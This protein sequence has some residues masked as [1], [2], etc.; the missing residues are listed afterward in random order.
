MTPKIIPVRQA[1]S[2]ETDG[3][4]LCLWR[5]S[6]QMRNLQDQLHDHSFRILPGRCLLCQERSRRAIDLC[7]DCESNLPW[8]HNACEFCGTSLSGE[9]R[10]CGSCLRSPPAF[11]ATFCAFVYEFPV[12][13]LLHRFKDQR[14][15]VSGQILS[16]L[17]SRAAADFLQP[18][19]PLKPVIV[20]VP[21]HPLR[22]LSRGFN[23]SA[24]IA[25]LLA[26]ALS[27]NTASL[28]SRNRFTGS[29]K[30]LDRHTRQKNIRGAFTAR[31][32][33]R[34]TTAILVDDVITTGATADDCTRALR[35]AGIDN[36]V[37]VAIAR[38]PAAPER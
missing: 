10:I 14:D 9:G 28:L 37:V 29:Q 20:P 4:N 16:R 35:H 8:N 34:H 24:I 7:P 13:R 1:R 6:G 26:D 11:S 25:G 38:T 32:S 5:Y 23:Q 3:T 21:L 31:N 33:H 30:Q 12:N 2:L 19:I 22:Y 15:L 27:L 36:V 18:L 17:L